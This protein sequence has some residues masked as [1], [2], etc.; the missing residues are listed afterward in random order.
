[1][2]SQTADSFD[3]SRGRLRQWLDR[4]PRRRPS[5]M[6]RHDLTEEPRVMTITK[7]TNE[8]ARGVAFLPRNDIGR[9]TTVNLYPRWESSKCRLSSAC[10]F[11]ACPA[12]KR[13]K[14]GSVSNADEASFVTEGNET[15]G[16]SP[17]GITLCTE[18][19]ADW[20]VI[21]RFV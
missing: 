14:G 15:H 18:P 5:H 20:L 9:K 4:I 6:P 1:M 8:E 21:P 12:G 7:E 19:E 3:P 2:Y 11:Q 13:D 10:K 16:A 17:F